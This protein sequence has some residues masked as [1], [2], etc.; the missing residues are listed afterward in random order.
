MIKP[1]TA[2]ADVLCKR[3]ILKDITVTYNLP[4]EKMPSYR[5]WPPRFPRQNIPREFEEIS[6]PQKTPE[7]ERCFFEMETPPDVAMGALSMGETSTQRTVGSV[8]PPNDPAAPVASS[9]KPKS[10]GENQHVV[11]PFITLH[12][13]P[14]ETII[15]GVKRTY[16]R[17]KVVATW[18]S[19]DVFIPYHRYYQAPIDV[20]LPFDMTLK[21]VHLDPKEGQTENISDIVI[22]TPADLIRKGWKAEYWPI[23]QEGQTIVPTDMGVFKSKEDYKRQQEWDKMF[24][25]RALS[26]NTYRT[27]IVD[28][29]GRFQGM[30]G[31]SWNSERDP[32]SIRREKS[33][34]RPKQSFSPLLKVAVHRD[35]R[36]FID[37]YTTGKLLSPPPS[38]SPSGESWQ[39]S[40]IDSG[41]SV[42]VP[43]D[44]V[45][46]HQKGSYQ[47][48]PFRPDKPRPAST[49][50][51]S[52]LRSFWSRRHSLS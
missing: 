14:G 18:K 41:V 44:G 45:Y 39:S 38:P 26:K 22:Q 9:S 13:P 36:D 34:K 51:A 31:F 28:R 17:Q 24:K 42:V 3:K 33:S 21:T 12:V 48:L 47:P 29:L 4:P 8:I 35:K 52:S 43:Q 40:S 30:L 49:D 32:E 46:T 10:K 1:K 50:A 25:E 2:T 16:K 27:E 19:K 6:N 7:N 23:L 37:Q 11:F 20:S 5:Y 15:N